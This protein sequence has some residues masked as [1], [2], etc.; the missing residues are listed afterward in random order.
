MFC[1]VSNRPI[2]NLK[3]EE[4]IRR[5]TSIYTVLINNKIEKTVKNSKTLYENYIFS[6][7]EVGRSKFCSNGTNGLFMKII[8]VDFK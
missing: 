2:D 3:N 5:K 8:K 1:L 6:N 7:T 4:L